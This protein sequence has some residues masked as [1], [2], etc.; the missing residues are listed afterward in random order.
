[1]TTIR[2][3]VE[4]AFPFVQRMGLRLDHIEPGRVRMT[5]PLEPNTN[6]IGTMYACLLYTSPSPRDS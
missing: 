3:L 1:M 6:H 5:C 2:P 4:K